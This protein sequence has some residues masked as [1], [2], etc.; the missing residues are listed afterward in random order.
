VGH[1]P[2][3]LEA[4]VDALNVRDNGIYV[5][6]TFGRGGHASAIAERLGPSGRLL[7][8]DADPEAVEHGRA[9][10]GDDARV[11]LVQANFRDLITTVRDHV[12]GRVDGVLMDLGVSSPQL[13]SPERGFSFR[14]D[15]PLDMRMDPS[16]G[17]SAADWLAD[18]EADELSRVIATFGEERFARRI[19]RAIV[20]ERDRAPI[21]TTGRLADIVRDAIPAAAARSSRI[22]PATRTFQA[23]RIAVNAEIDALDEALAGAIDVLAPGGRLAVISF[24]SLEDRR[25]KR[26]IREASTPPPASRRAPAPVRFRPRLKR[27]GGLVRPSEAEAAANPR[28]RSARMRVAERLDDV[29]GAP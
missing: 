1:V 10:F 11:R 16:A 7:A 14:A 18:I 25:V 23:L 8:I 27:I 4:A 6:A 22:D 21:R 9:R 24:H 29:E 15:G 26:A 19:A 3:L 12:D 2:V 28:A 17:P 5:D 20:A 13:D